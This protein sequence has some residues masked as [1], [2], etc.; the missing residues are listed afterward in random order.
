MGLMTAVQLDFP[1]KAVVDQAQARGVI[2][3]CTHDTVL[4]F[5]P[6]YIVQERHIDEVIRVL[7]AVIPAV[8]SQQS[9]AKRK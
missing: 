4:R 2:I 8:Q 3:N 1:G 5:L 6:P 9:G 7:D